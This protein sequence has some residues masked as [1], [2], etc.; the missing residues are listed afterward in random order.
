MLAESNKEKLS[1]VIGQANYET[2]VKG[3]VRASNAE[4]VGFPYDTAWD[5]TEGVLLR[6]RGSTPRS[7]RSDWRS[8]G[9]IPSCEKHRMEKH[10]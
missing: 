4:K 6:W 8:S 1:K 10:V 5:F 3:E 7:R 2:S 9:S